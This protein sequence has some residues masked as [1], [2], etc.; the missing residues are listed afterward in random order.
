MSTQITLESLMTARQVPQ[1][2]RLALSTIY[3]K[4]HEGTIPCVKI[5]EAVRFLPSAIQAWL[6]AQAKPA[7]LQRVPTVEV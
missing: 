7:R 4:V 5:G 2:R 1:V 6:D 3:M